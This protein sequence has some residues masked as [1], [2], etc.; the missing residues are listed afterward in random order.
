M[1]ARVLFLI[2]TLDRSGAEKQLALLA[3]GGHGSAFE[4]SVVCLDRGGSLEQPLVD[5]GV[6]I[7]VLGKR[8]KFDFAALRQLRK[9]VE[10][11]RPDVAHSWLFAGLA[12]NALGCWG[13]RR[14]HSFRCVDLWMG[15]KER[16]ATKVFAGRIDRF[17]ANSAAVA[18]WYGQLGV[19]PIHT[20]PNAIAAGP[21]NG[22]G[23]RDE[24]GLPPDAKL[25]LVVGRLAKQKRIRDLLWGFQLLRQTDER[26][27]LAIV[28]DGSLRS[29]LEEHAVKLECASRTRFLGHRDDVP[30]L[31]AAADA[32]WLG[33]DF[34]GQSNSVMEAMAA[35]VPVVATS[36]EPNRELITHGESGYL[37]N[38]GDSVAFAQFTA[39]LF[40]DDA[41]SLSLADA[42]RQRIE[43]QHNVADMI[44][45]YAAI[46]DD[47]ASGGRG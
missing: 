17:T 2:P 8:G 37:A 45:A 14:L 27:Y 11:F 25:V 5:A 13:V 24:L 4:A 33:S 35:G 3:A 28:G 18:D 29:E 34:E 19:G 44:A 31:L 1:P 23:I 32:F 42:A 22:D 30:D 15:R 41:L 7:T 20:V 16:L 38:V 6:P 9:T 40:A 43:S 47:L 12:Y 26:A 21:G 39:K 46:Y 10:T 36:I